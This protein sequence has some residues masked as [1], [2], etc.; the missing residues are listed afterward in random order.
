MSCN[1][2][3]YRKIK[4]FE[5][6]EYPGISRKDTSYYLKNLCAISTNISIS[7]R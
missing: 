6:S 2:K 3:K 1:A 4:G 7:D 5:K